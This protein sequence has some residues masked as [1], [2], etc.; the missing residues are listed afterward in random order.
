MTT[1]K[2]KRAFAMAGITMPSVRAHIERNLT[3]HRAALD[4]VTSRQLAAV[5][6]VHHMAYHQGRASCGAERLDGN[7]QDGLYWLGGRDGV[8]VEMVGGAPR[9]NA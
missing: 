8:A 2:I 7:A 4:A 6:A 3:A 1:T 9:L 5:I